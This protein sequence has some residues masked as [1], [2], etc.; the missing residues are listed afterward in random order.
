MK[1]KT[2]LADPPWQYKSKTGREWKH[3]SDKKYSTMTTDL[4]C[5]L[6]IIDQI[7]DKNCVLFLWATIPLLPDAF[8]V[9][10]SW[11]FHYKTSIIW[12]KIM[13]MGMGFWFRGQC[14]MCLIGI[15]GQV[16]A[17]RCQKPNFIQAKVFEHSKKPEE[18]FKLIDPIIPHPAIELFARDKR[19]G[20]D[21]WGLETNRFDGT[22]LFGEAL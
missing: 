16:K 17:F 22:R 10:E 12:R 18:F 3:G 4:I 20:W 13:S 15:K 8:K 7:A 6:A 11:K 21:S 19:K 5:D 1:Y 14:E 2:I 9:M